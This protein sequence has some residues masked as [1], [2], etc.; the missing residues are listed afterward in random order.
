MNEQTERQFA[1][2]VV[3]LATMTGWLVKRDPS[4]RAT[5]ASPG[6][7]DLTMVRNGVLIFAE[8]KLDKAR[9]KPTEAQEAWLAALRLAPSPWVRVCVW[10]PSMWPSIE[11]TLR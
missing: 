10:R 2:A 5:A 11:E 8:L 4:W 3:G 6:Y 1:D 7:P 9:S